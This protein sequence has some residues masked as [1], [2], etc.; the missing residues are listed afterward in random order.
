MV[1]ENRPGAG[2]AIGARAVAAAP[3]EGYTLMAG[4]TSVLRSD[5]GRVDSGRKVST[6]I[7]MPSSPKTA[8]RRSIA[9]RIAPRSHKAG[10]WEA[11]GA[12]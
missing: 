10:R 3:A 7:D 11:V 1:I 5:P 8:E 4:N 6:G 2:G 9:C 12:L